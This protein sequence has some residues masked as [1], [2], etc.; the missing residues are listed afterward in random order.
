M[1]WEIVHP[2]N[3][4]ELIRVSVFKRVL[5]QT[6]RN[7]VYSLENEPVGE[8][9]IF[10]YEWYRAKTRLAQRKKCNSEMACWQRQLHHLHLHNEV[11]T[12]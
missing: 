2:Q 6:F 10:S 4:P 11:K 3:A 9:D 7:E 12:G 1:G 8:T 5:R